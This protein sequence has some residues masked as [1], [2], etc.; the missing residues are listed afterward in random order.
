MSWSAYNT[1][2]QVQS[3]PFTEPY[4]SL[5]FRIRTI[6]IVFNIFSIVI[7]SPDVIHHF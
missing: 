1:G 6:F 2:M 3:L 7:F 4:D 5:D